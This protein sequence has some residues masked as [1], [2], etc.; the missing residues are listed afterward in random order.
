MKLFS[1]A[2]GSHVRSMKFV[3]FPAPQ[4]MVLV[5]VAW[6]GNA[7]AQTY[8]AS[9]TPPTPDYFAFDA[10]LAWRFKQWELAVIGKN[11]WDNSHPEF[12]SEIPRSVYG[13][14]SWSF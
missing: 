6:A 1:A 2:P 5:F 12:R 3:G 4:L 13:K 14:V 8:A 9:G 11:L 7:L 10:R